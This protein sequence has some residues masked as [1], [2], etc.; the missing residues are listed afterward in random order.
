MGGDVLATS[1]I[2]KINS[3]QDLK[4]T[5]CIVFAGSHSK[6]QLSGNQTSGGWSSLIDKHNLQEIITVSLPT[7]WTFDQEIDTPYI[8]TVFNQSTEN[9]KK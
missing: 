3:I 6:R 4:K 9:S 7:V 2:E 5:T 1:I 8:Y